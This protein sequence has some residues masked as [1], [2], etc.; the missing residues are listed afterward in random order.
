MTMKTKIVVILGPT[1]SGKTGVAIELARRFGGEIVSADSLQVY[2]GADIGTAKATAAERAAVPHHLIDVAEPWE[3]YTAARY[4]EEARSAVADI[5]ARGRVPFVVGGTGLYIRVLTKG[6]TDTG[7]REA[8]RRIREELVLAAEEK[9]DAHLYDE[10]RRLDPDTAA[11]IHP[12]NLRRVMRALEICISTGAPVSKLRK[13]HA[14]TDTPYDCL[15]IGLFVP[16]AEL[17]KAI[18]ERVERMISAGLLEETRRLVAKGEEG[19][20]RGYKAGGLKIGAGL[21]YKEMLGYMEGRLTM[22]EAI[23]EMKKKTR[24][25]AKRQMTW[26]RKEEGVRWFSPG[27]TGGMADAVSAHLGV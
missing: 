13:A 7:D 15:R 11:D 16:R 4:M 3:E 20:S 24:H 26:F 5:A 27:E 21:G 9:G 1:A 23:G 6:L 2:K 17:Y 18:E 10:L 22:E 14:F 25:Y 19:E 12:N 8:E